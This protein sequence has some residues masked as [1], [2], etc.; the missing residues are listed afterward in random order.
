M[1]LKSS[2]CPFCKHRG[3]PFDLIPTLYV[4]EVCGIFTKPAFGVADAIDDEELRKK[5]PEKIRELDLQVEEARR[6]IQR[7]SNMGQL[8]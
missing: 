1:L 7:L 6:K 5:I 2:K 8:V 4:C 3:V